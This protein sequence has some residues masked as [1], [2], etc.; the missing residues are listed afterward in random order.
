[1][2]GERSESADMA[3]HSPPSVSAETQE[4]V[5][6]VVENHR[7]FLRYVERRVGNRAVADPTLRSDLTQHCQ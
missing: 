5:D 6:Q 3:D 2:K 1:M 7:E 4:I